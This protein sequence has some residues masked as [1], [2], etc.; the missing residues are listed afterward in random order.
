MS[1]QR[2]ELN[3]LLRPY[4]PG[5]AECLLKGVQSYEVG[6]YLNLPGSQTLAQ[7]QAY[8][9]RSQDDPLSYHW[10]ICVRDDDGE[11][12]PIGTTS[13]HRDADRPMGHSG[14]VIFD[15]EWWG[16]GVAS[17]AHLARTLYAYNV[18]DWLAIRSAV[19]HGNAGSKKALQKVG[20]TK[21]GTSYAI[22]MVDGRVVHQDDLL[23]INPSERSWNY[24]WGDT[25]P[26]QALVTARTRTAAALQ[27]AE[28]VVTFD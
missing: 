26:P 23:C 21:V 16:R 22:R 25:K 13:L 8:L 10:A 2:G 9:D 24:F 17:S 4:A 27:L 18:L 19:L 11:G 1:I 6:R 14:I 15:R 12:T 28:Q 20:Y 5:E 3:L 7:E